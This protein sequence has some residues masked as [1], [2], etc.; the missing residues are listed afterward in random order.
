MHHAKVP[1]PV[2]VLAG[3]SCSVADQRI[4]PASSVSE[5]V[6]FGKR[7]QE[8]FGDATRKGFYGIID[9]IK[10]LWWLRIGHQLGGDAYA[11]AAKRMGVSR[12]TAFRIV[13]LYPHLDKI[14]RWAEDAAC[15]QR[16]RRLTP[17]WPCVAEML[18]RFP[19]SKGGSRRRIPL[20]EKL[21]AT[22]LELTDKVTTLTGELA[23][24]KRREAE[25]RRTIR[26]QNAQI[27]RLENER[28]PK[29]RGG[30]SNDKGYVLTPGLPNRLHSEFGEIDACHNPRIA[31]L[32]PLMQEWEGIKFNRV[33][34]MPCARTFTVQPIKELLARYEVGAFVRRALQCA[35]GLGT[36]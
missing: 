5:I 23:A 19:T 17:T 28:V 24:A 20:L 8:R 33:W 12:P 27:E 16:Q 32:D 10:A 14:V 21:R 2:Q 26:L 6:R 30:R 13:H 34:A 29:S 36:L 15:V 22:N 4:G 3:D 1:L 11:R 35:S 18:R 25:L 7:A 9:T 31:G